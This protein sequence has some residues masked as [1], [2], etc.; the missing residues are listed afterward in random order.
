[1]NIKTEGQIAFANKIIDDVENMLKKQNIN[2][3]KNKVIYFTEEAL[4]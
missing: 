3:F 1:M 4:K 2:I